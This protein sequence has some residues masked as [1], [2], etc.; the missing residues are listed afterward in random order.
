MGRGGAAGRRYLRPVNA[1][2]ACRTGTCELCGGHGREL[3]ILAMP[4]FIGWACGECR[5]QLNGCILR[6]FCGTVEHTD[7]AE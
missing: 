4:D 7:P 1:A 2:D 3:R 5:T 6:R